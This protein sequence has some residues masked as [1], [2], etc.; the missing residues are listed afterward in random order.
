MQTISDAIL[1][2]YIEE[3]LPVEQM[4]MLETQ[5]RGDS[6]LQRRLHSLIAQRD[7]GLHSIGDI[8]RRHRISC[9]TREE[10]GSYLLSAMTDEQM[11]YINFHLEEL[12]CRYCQSN[13][14]DLKAS[15]QRDSV[16]ARRRKY[17]Q[18]SV[19][20]LRAER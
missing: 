6:E 7:Q 17:F 11:T 10:L 3:S 19:G 14:T 20:R 12:G 4:T 2:G 18:S 8:W 5:L 16:A 15:Q 13:L 1:L 9:P